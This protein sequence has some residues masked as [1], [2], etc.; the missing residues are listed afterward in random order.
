MSRGDAA[1]S[2]VPKP[3]EWDLEHPEQSFPNPRHV[4]NGDLSREVG[5]CSPICL[6]I[7]G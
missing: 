7:V 1:R 4:W 3:Q 2:W 5:K 6:G